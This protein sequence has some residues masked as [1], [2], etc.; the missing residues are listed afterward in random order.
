MDVPPPL[1]PADGPADSAAAG[2]AVGPVEQLLAPLDWGR[3]RQELF[4]GLTAAVVALP[5]ALAFGVASGAGAAAGL[6][7]AVLVGLV[8]AL[9]GRTPALISEP[10]GPMTVVMTGVIASLSAQV[11]DP[12][13]ALALAFTVVM[14]AGLLQIA[15]GLLRLGRYITQMPYPVISG[16]ISGVGVILVSLQLAPLLGQPLPAGGALGSLRAL[17]QLIAAGQPLEFGLGA[18]TLLILWGTPQRLRQLLP[19]PLIALLVGT[20]LSLWLPGLPDDL[21]RIGPI[22]AGLPQWHGPLLPVGLPFSPLLQGDLLRQI[23][24]DAAVL[25]L[26]GSI[27]AL[28]TAVIADSLTRRQHDS[29]RELVA[30]GLAN[31]VSGLGGAL[32]GAGATMGT[33]VNIQAGGRSALSGLFRAAILLLV[34]LVGAPLAA[35]IPQAVLAGIALKVGVDIVDWDFLGR[36]LRLS[37]R[38]ALVMALVLVLTVAVDL[39]VAVVVGV[40]LANLLTID[41]LSALQSQAVRSAGASGDAISGTDDAVLLAEPE[42]DLLQQAQGRVLLLQLSGPMIYGVARAIA[43][44]QQR[45]AAGPAA[46]ALVVDLTEVSHLGVSAALALENAV[47]D[48]LEGGLAV[49]VCGGSG[50][51]AERLQRLRLAQLLPA[52]HLDLPRQRALELALAAAQAA[53]DGAIAAPLPAT[54][55]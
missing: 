27:D 10:T 52:D 22:A 19:A 7:G 55:A 30:Q 32:P 37:R 48:A 44:E 11:P 25:A 12:A 18:L 47:R 15:F 54:L 41:R 28:L 17:P 4:G 5:L 2:P 39:V 42:R 38:G 45:I 46:A 31:L 26:L 50:A 33:V 36:A 43:R 20:A 16:F 29:D 49:F 8:A 53:L 13:T 21:R 1:A 6:W 3:W 9:F 40:F 23:G 14:L 24:V 34:I 51:T 35:Q